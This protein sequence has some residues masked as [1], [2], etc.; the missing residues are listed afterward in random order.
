M[1]KLYC[2]F[3]HDAIPVF[4]RVNTLLQNDEPCIPVLRRELIALLMD[5]YA[6]FLKPKIVASASDILLIKPEK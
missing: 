1:T 5:L 6:R 3:V 2:M 4:D